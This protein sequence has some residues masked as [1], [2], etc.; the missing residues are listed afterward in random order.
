[1]LTEFG[2]EANGLNA[3][4]APGGDA[5]QARLIEQQLR[6][7]RR[8]RR[9]GGWLVWALQDFALTPT[10]GGGSVRQALP[11]LRLVPGINQKGL[12]TYGGRAKPAAAVVRR[13][14]PRDGTAAP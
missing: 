14:S 13:L 9:L 2:A 10:F 5:Y 7:L 4:G 8:D 11:S 12:F 3:P 1:V 6:V